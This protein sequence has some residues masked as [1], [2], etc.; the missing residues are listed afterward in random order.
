VFDGEKH[1]SGSSLD[2]FSPDLEALLTALLACEEPSS[3]P[4]RT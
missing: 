1:E 3:R 4:L 2:F